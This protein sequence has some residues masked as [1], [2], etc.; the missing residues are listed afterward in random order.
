MRSKISTRHF[1]LHLHTSDPRC[2]SIQTQS[3]MSIREHW[4]QCS[5]RNLKN[6][7][8]ISSNVS[9]SVS[10]HYLLFSSEFSPSELYLFSSNKL[11]EKLILISS[12][13]PWLFL[14]D[15]NSVA[16]SP[17]DKLLASGSQDRTA[18]LWS[19][20]GEGTM[21]L[22][23]VFRG[24]RRGVWAV[25]FSPVDQVLATTSA[26][27][28]TKLWSLQDFSCLKVGHEIKSAYIIEFRV[29]YIT[30]NDHSLNTSSISY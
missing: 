30:G 24:H 11:N 13:P 16:V 3:K 2:L 18:K 5:E 23:G 7:S 21:G 29:S 6:L 4:R 27:G 10:Q 8:S 9:I 28:T 14:Q 22:L 25:C 12:S 17:N 15:V 19:L 26:D 20:A 1:L